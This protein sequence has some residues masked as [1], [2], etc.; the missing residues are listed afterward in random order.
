MINRMIERQRL[1]DRRDESRAP[2]AGRITWRYPGDSELFSGWLSDGSHCSV[3]FITA[4]SR[5][6]AGSELIE[7]VEPNGRARTYE[8]TRTSL[9]DETLS[10]VA[11]QVVVTAPPLVA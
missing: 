4:T 9:Y 8:V 2:S 5:G 1:L 10:L 3:S 6:P 7:I 11:C